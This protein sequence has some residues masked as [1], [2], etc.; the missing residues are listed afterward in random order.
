[1]DTV[2]QLFKALSENV[3]L[4]ILALLANG[5]LC[6]CD[7]MAALE[8]PQ[9]TVSRHLAKLR[10]AGLV[11]GRR[12]GTW[13]HYRLADPKDELSRAINHIIFGPLLDDDQSWL[14]AERLAQHL[15]NKQ[16]SS[17]NSCS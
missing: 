4:R 5:E 1:M 14:D 12:N 11:T 9:S 8:L 17:V 16:H 6:V 7:L 15:K 2:A 10:S 3:R 13:M